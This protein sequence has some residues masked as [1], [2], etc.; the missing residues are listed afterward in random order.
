MLWNR[1]LVGK[2]QIL[3]LLAGEGCREAGG[4]WSPSTLG[5]GDVVLAAQ[6]PSFNT[7]IRNSLGNLIFLL[8]ATLLTISH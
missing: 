8:Q 6:L 3:G 4:T 7:G 1:V 2:V 5:T